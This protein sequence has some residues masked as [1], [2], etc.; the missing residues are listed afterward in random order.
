MLWK[1]ALK[2]LKTCQRPWGLVPWSPTRYPDPSPICVTLNTE[3]WISPSF[4]W[5]DY[6]SCD[7]LKKLLGFFRP[8]SYK[9][10]SVTGKRLQSLTYARHSWPLNSERCHTYYDIRL[11]WLSP[12][13]FDTH[14]YNRAFNSGAVTA[15]FN[16]LG[17]SRLGFKPPKFHIEH[18]W[19]KLRHP[20]V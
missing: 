8:S 6:D 10:L 3:S 16:D 13:T 9:D 15:C 17:L 1:K 11:L 12:K 20:F 5:N 7:F 18:P 14:T 4:T 2:T 19:T